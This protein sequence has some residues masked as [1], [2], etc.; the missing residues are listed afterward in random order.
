MVTTESSRR[1][2][3]RTPR[4]RRFT[5]VWLREQ[6]G[7]QRPAREEWGDA[8]RPGLRA[9]FGKSGSITWVHYRT[10]G[11]KQTMT[12]LGRYPDLGLAGARD[13]LD[14]E[15]SRSRVGLA[16]VEVVVADADMTVDG[17]V[18]KFCT[19]LATRRKHPKRP[20]RMLE[21]TLLERRHG[22]RFLKVR[23]V[24]KPAWRAVIEEIAARG[25]RT[26]AAHTF[27]LMQQMFDYAVQLEV[28]ESNPFTGLDMSTLGAAPSKPRQRILTVDELHAL[29]VVLDA[30][31][32]RDA[33]V[34]RLALKLLLLTGKRVGELLRTRW[35]DL[36]LEGKAP[37]WTIP[38]ANRKSTVDAPLPDEVVPLAPAAVQVFEALKEKKRSDEWVF[39]SPHSS[40]DGRLAD[41]APSRIVRELFKAKRLKG[42]EWT[43]HDLRRTARTLWADKLKV[44]WHVSE[45]LLGHALPKVAAT[46]A[47]TTYPEERREAL[48]RW[49][50]FLGQLHQGGG[51]VVFINAQGRRR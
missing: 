8:D 44:A 1:S 43:P 10:V 15:R 36:D 32:Q 27:K 28:L 48:E 30:P 49:A 17:L 35:S 39:A 2:P 6:L 26:E 31:C 13:R 50:L 3:K 33:K 7:K 38:G 9:R 42:P 12:V 51:K 46:Y 14:T 4:V 19:Y 21:R 16:G 29:L 45:V 24:A 18:T 20:E 5:E 11:G 23:D 41:T 34:G 37:A 25:T 40:Q 22:F 47:V